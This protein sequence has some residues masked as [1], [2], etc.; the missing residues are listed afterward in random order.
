M[1]LTWKS[2]VHYVVWELQLKARKKY[3]FQYNEI[4]DI[5]FRVSCFVLVSVQYLQTN[6]DVISYKAVAMISLPL[7]ICPLE[8]AL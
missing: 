3:K 8:S 6:I 2:E 5:I 4:L 1:L 7:D